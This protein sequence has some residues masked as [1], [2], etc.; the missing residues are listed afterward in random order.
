[1]S[2]LRL[3][4]GTITLRPYVFVFLAAYLVLAIRS[5]GWYRTLLYTVTGYGLAWA[6]EYSSIHTGFPFGWYEY[7]SA[8]TLDRELW[9]AGVPFMDSLSFVFLTFAGLQVARLILQPLTWRSARLSDLEWTGPSSSIGWSTWFLAGLLTMGLDLVIDPVA[10]HGD[11]WFL[12]QIYHYPGGGIYFGVP[13]SNFAGWALLAWAII[14]LN[15]WL[16]RVLLRRWWG[17]WEDRPLDALGAAGLFAGVLAFNLAV[18]F[19]IGR[20]VQGLIGCLLAALMLAPVL[21]RLPRARLL[22]QPSAD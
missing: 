8:P 6:A 19:A 21:I 17:P 7:F 4:A 1:M 16:D 5:W 20:S 9:I 2:F 11:Q 18:T 15:L 22:S 10:L 3:L 13:L 12:G 14:G